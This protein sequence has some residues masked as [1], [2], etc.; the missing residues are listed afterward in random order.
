MQYAHYS[1]KIAELIGSEERTFAQCKEHEAQHRPCGWGDTL[2]QENDRSVHLNGGVNNEHRAEWTH[3]TQWRGYE[4][5][6]V[7]K[8]EVGMTCEECVSK[9]ERERGQLDLEECE[10]SPERCNKSA[11]QTQH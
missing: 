9:T 2:Q 7:S 10:W 8:R 1:Y 5:T 6:I 11:Q 4:K 3:L